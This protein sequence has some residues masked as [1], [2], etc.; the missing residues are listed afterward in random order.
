MA[1]G[2][3]GKSDGDGGG[4]ALKPWELHGEGREFEKLGRELGKAVGALEKDLAALGA[5]WG[6]DQPGSAFAAVY[7]PAHGEL[8]GGLKALAGQVGKVG[9]GLHT[10]AERTTDTDTTTADGFGGNVGPAG[11]APGAVARPAVYQGP[12]AT[13]GT[14]ATPGAAPAV[15]RS[16]SV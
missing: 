3:T 10:M 4:F 14:G 13:A 16:M 6:A 15:P 2:S 12:P 1:G 8:L 5:P 7:G 9:A 11:D